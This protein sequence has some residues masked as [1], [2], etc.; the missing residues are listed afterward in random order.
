MTAPARRPVIV[1]AAQITQRL[2]DPSQAGSPLDL[3]ERA[4]RA[5]AEDAGAPDLSTRLDGIYVPQ[6]LW[7][8]GDPGRMLGERLG[9][10]RA[11][12]MIGAVSGHIVQVLV[13][14]ACDE[15]ARGERDVVALVG[16]E[17]ENSRRRLARRGLPLHWSEDA[18]GEPDARVGEIKWV[19]S[20]D[21]ERAGLYTA[22]AIFALGETALRRTR[23]ETPA[24]HRDRIAALSEGMSRIAAR[25]PRAWFQEPVPAS[26]IREPAAGNRMVHYPYTKLMTSNIAVDQSAALLICSEETADRLGVPKAKRVYLRVATE[27]SHTLLLSERPGLDRHEGQALA[28]RRMLEIAD[29]GPEDLD[30]VDLYSC[31]PF[32]VQAGAAALGVGLDPLPSL[33]GGMTFFGGPFGNYVLHSKATLVEALRRDPGSLGAI[34]SVGGSFAHFAFGLYSTE[35]GDSVR[36]RVEDVS[37]AL[38]R[39]PRRGYVVGYE[40]EATIETYTVECDASGPRHAIF[41]G[42]TDAGE[43]VWG[44]AADRDLLDA[45]L[46]DEEGAGRRARFSNC[47]VE[48]R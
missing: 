29:I 4:I 45:L 46:A 17:S 30:H 19:R 40:G 21:E 1:G 15:I 31:F 14:R 8:Y 18:P 36:P 28:A 34:G 6:G 38:A 43:R 24:A 7:K 13:D 25:H 3:M 5:A 9:S 11:K 33:T 16:G 27:M 10:P 44:R 41:A 35:P 37:A 48:V 39:L 23:G 32:A 42:L 47:E 20:P 22:T 26:R 2:D 12:T